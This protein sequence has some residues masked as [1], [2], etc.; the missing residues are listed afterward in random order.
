VK[1]GIEK[2]SAARKINIGESGWPL[3]AEYSSV[4]YCA[5]FGQGFFV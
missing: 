1:L 4:P 3:L 2:K 5:R